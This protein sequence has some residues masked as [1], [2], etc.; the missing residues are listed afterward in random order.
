MDV[1]ESERCPQPT[2]MA[3]DGKQERSIDKNDSK[4]ERQREREQ[5]GDRVVEREQHNPLIQDFGHCALQRGSAASP[6]GC[7]SAGM[8]PFLFQVVL[9]AQEKQC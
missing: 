7:V 2:E 3:D 9:L 1:M 5:E 4:T 8:Y 6:V